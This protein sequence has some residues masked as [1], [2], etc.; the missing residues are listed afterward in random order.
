MSTVTLQFRIAFINHI[1][2]ASG[3]P[4]YSAMT[5]MQKHAAKGEL[6]APLMSTVMSNLLLQWS[7]LLVSIDAGCCELDDASMRALVEAEL[8]K[9]R[10]VLQG[11][12]GFE[13][14][15]GAGDPAALCLKIPDC[16]HRC[17]RIYDVTHGAGGGAWLVHSP[18]T[19]VVGQMRLIVEWTTP[20]GVTGGTSGGGHVH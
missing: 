18:S 19:G 8:M 7:A 2:V 20:P 6:L 5:P 9:A 4:K 11:A 16:S 12:L 3:T 14:A 13:P 17:S 1:D 15:L 10:V